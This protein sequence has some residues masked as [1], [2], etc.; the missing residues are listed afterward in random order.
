MGTSQKSIIRGT[1]AAIALGFILPLLAAAPAQAAAHCT[2]IGTNDSY[3]T[4]SCTGTGYAQVNVRCNA[5]WPFT[6][7]T[8]YGPRVYLNGG[9][10]VINAHI[11]CA[12]SM[13]VWVV[14]G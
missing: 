14:Y 4:A 9:G 12:A 11:Y 3:A 7:W 1:I 2:N 10:N 8:D 13:T 6:K 5:I